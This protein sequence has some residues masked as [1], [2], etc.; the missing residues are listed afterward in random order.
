[1]SSPA[2]CVWQLTCYIQIRNVCTIPI[3][4][5]MEMPSAILPVYNIEAPLAG[6]KRRGQHIDIETGDLIL[7]PAG[8]LGN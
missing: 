3:F 2:Y 4:R 8:I 6:R 5:H 7:A 1:M